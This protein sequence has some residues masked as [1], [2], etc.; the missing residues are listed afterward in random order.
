MR[1]AL[2]WGVFLAALF[3]ALLC[4]VAI[5]R[6]QW[7][8]NERLPFPLATI[9]LSLVDEPQ[10]GRY[11]SRTLATRS[12]WIAITLIFFIHLWNGAAQYL[13]QHFP[14]IPVWYDLSNVLTE[15]PWAYADFKLKNAAVFFTVVGVT[16]FL[17]GAIAFS[18]WAFFLLEQARHMVLGTLS[19]DPTVYGWQDEHFGGILAFAAVVLWIGRR[20]WR[21]VVAQALRGA[22]PG[23]PRGRYAPYPLALWGLLCCCIVM[24]GWLVAAGSTVTGACVMVAML[25]LLF[26]IITRIIAETGLVLGQLQVGLYRPWQLLAI[27]GWTD[28]VPLKTFYLTALVNGQFYDFREVLSVYASHGLKVADQT[29]LP[30]TSDDDDSAADRRR[31]RRLIALMALALLVGYAVS[32]TSTLWTEYRY[33]A[34]RDVSA[35]APINDWGTDI[36][37]KRQ[38]LDP[39]QQYGA[40]DYHVGYSPAGHVAF[41]FAFTTLLGFLRL[42]YAWWPLHPVGYLMVGTYPEQHLWLSIFLGWAAKAVIVRLGGSRLYTHAKPFFLGL[43]VGE[44]MAAGFWLVMGIV[45]GSM[46]LPYR[47]INIM[48]G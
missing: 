7:F 26:I 31:G 2:T 5:V 18:L 4:L 40:G 35:R 44:S 3:G 11:F 45:L 37:P 27:Y 38:I 30:A 1:P 13:P 6:R 14:R 42:R 17:P 29:M 16:Y 34:T 12:F 28:A 20:H 24:A 43:I 9:Y 39:T 15:P 36:S 32:F 33:A 41:G 25:L 10:P 19:G 48:P 8:E 47:P 23:E 21:L 46:N 22:R